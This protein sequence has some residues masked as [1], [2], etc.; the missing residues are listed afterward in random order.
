MTIV[1]FFTTTVAFGQSEGIKFGFELGG[2]PKS[3]DKSLG[4]DSPAPSGYIGFYTN[5]PLAKRLFIKFGAGMYN[6]LFHSAE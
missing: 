4:F 3:T 6:T 2:G 5:R 1:T